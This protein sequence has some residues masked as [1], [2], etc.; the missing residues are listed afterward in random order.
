MPP[1]YAPSPLMDSIGAMASL[2]GCLT[3]STKRNGHPQKLCYH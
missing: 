2:G 1:G 3:F